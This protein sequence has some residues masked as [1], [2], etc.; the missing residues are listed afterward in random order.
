M[1]D[2]R[3]A[4][5]WVRE[6]LARHEAPLLHYATRLLLG[7]RERARDAVQE[8]FA[9]LC[10]QDPAEVSA[11]QRPEWL[12]TVCRRVALDI[13]RKEARMAP[14]DESLAQ[15]QRSPAPSPAES[16]ERRE[17]S[18]QVRQ[19]LAALSETQ[20]EVLRLKFQN[21][22]SY[23]EI[24]RVTGLSVSHVGV[25]LHLGLKRVR[26]RLGVAASPPV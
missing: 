12:F 26:E 19:A 14:L 25:Q 13:R 21:G 3:T 7:D 2:G 17:T 24:A 6:A 4:D 22:F 20:Q 9:R 5:A 8:T 10:Q 18:A 11:R 15:A 23:K 1:D 16:L